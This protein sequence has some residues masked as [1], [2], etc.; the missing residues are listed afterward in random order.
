MDITLFAISL[1]IVI[2]ILFLLIFLSKSFNKKTL[3]AADG[4]IFSKTSD[5]EAY[6]SIYEKTKPLFESFEDKGSREEILGFEKSF[7]IQIK[8]LHEE[9]L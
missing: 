4:S 1:F 7:L 9:K 5:L 3:K 6:E 2:A 8:R